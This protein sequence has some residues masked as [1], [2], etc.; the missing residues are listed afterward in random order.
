MIGPPSTGKTLL[1]NDIIKHTNRVCPIQKIIDIPETSQEMSQIS[2]ISPADDR[3]GSVQAIRIQEE[4]LEKQFAKEAA[5][6]N[7]VEQRN[8]SEGTLVLADR[9]GADAV[10]FVEAYGDEEQARKLFE[11]QEWQVLRQ[12]MRDSLIILCEPV[13]PWY[14]GEGSIRRRVTWEKMNELYAAYKANLS[15]RY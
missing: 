7:E 12:R 10:V 4:L 3:A 8:A 15:L 6:A 14:V 11:S 2:L 13:T 1:I 9:S 5:R